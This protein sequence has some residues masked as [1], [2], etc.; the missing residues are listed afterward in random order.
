M[1][2][3]DHNVTINRKIYSLFDV[4]TIKEQLKYQSNHCTSYTSCKDFFK[5]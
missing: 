2:S 5:I 1:G 3:V 4:I